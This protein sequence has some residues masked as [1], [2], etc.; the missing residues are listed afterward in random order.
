MEQQHV[1]QHDESFWRFEFIDWKYVSLADLPYTKI[2]FLYSEYVRYLSIFIYCSISFTK[3][4]VTWIISCEFGW[5]PLVESY[6]SFLLGHLAGSI[7]WKTVWKVDPN[8]HIYQSSLFVTH[9]ATEN[10]I[11]SWYLMSIEWMLLIAWSLM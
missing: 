1:F 2:N 3:I 8:F 10:A 7:F 6:Q 5:G 11:Y 4:S 9:H